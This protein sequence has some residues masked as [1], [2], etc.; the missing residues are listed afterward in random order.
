VEDVKAEQ[1]KWKTLQAQV[2]F[3]TESYIL[4]CGGGIGCT[5]QNEWRTLQAQV[6]LK[7]ESYILDCGG[8]EG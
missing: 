3:Y 4:G 8:R 5:V 2:V 1:S 6:K 7:A